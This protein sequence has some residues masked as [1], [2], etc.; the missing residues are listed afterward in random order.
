MGWQHSIRTHTYLQSQHTD[1]GP[2]GQSSQFCGIPTYRTTPDIPAGSRPLSSQARGR[3]R[4]DTPRSR[5]TRNRRTWSNDQAW[6]PLPLLSWP[7]RALS[8]PSR[9]LSKLAKPPLSTIVSESI[10]IIQQHGGPENYV[11]DYI[12]IHPCPA[13]R[14]GTIRE[15]RR[16]TDYSWTTRYNIISK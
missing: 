7:L 9:Q 12:H 16:I 14:T 11:T 4:S 1:S 15:Q 3:C 5:K 2:K 10:G 13:P 8:S 6:L